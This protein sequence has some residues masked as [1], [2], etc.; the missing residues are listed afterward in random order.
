MNV[1]AAR[2]QLSPRAG[3]SLVFFQGCCHLDFS[4]FFIN[5][6]CH[7]ARARHPRD[8]DQSF[9]G[10]NCLQQV[11]PALLFQIFLYIKVPRASQASLFISHFP[12]WRRRTA[13][14][15][16][17]LW[18]A[19]DRGRYHRSGE[20]CSLPAQ[21][22]T[23]L[24][25]SPVVLNRRRTLYSWPVLQYLSLYLSARYCGPTPQAR[26]TNRVSFFYHVIQAVNKFRSTGGLTVKVF[27]STA[28][29]PGRRL[30]RQGA[31][32][33]LAFPFPPPV[34]HTVTQLPHPIRR[35]FL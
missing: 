21:T 10:A 5:P 16:M 33:Y 34:R 23:A 15:K 11:Q 26:D 17:P 29:L 8:L 35:M 25:I 28:F 31:G 14:L 20:L 13:R 30:I 12:F 7:P 18:T 32:Q 4:N 3:R 1:L 22:C 19:R 27:I 24:P 6:P 2:F 9:G